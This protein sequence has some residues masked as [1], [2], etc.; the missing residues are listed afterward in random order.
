NAVGAAISNSGP[1]GFNNRWDGNDFVMRS[2]AYISMDSRQQTE[3][4]VIRT[5][6][7]IGLNYDSPAAGSATLFSG[8]RAFVQF[9]GFTF[10]LAQSFFDFYSVPASSYWGIITSDTGDGGWKVAGYTANFGNG[11]TS[12]LAMEE[13]RRIGIINTNSDGNDPFTMFGAAVAQ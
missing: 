4:G 11:I 6:V 5:Y 2:R 10:G 7:N 12:T 8:N 9:A 1:N 13:P 3:F